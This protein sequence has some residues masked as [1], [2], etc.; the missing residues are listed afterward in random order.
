M[1]IAVY[2]RVSSKAQDTKSQ[3][4]DLERW[5]DAYANG[6]AVK[7]YRDKFTGKT[8]E[9]KG[10]KQL[11][12]DLEAG[13]VSKILVWRLDRIGRTA[14]GL[15]KLFDYLT[16]KKIT[17]ISIKDGLDLGTSAGRLMA[18]VLASV[19]QYET[20]V[21]AERVLAGQAVAK[22]NGKTWGGSERGRLVTVKP[23]Q[24]EAVKRYHAEGMKVAKI[25][26]TV[27]VSRPTVYRLLEQSA[28]C[29]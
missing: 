1:T 7:I 18:N 10:W 25:A 12:T 17:L 3:R 16:A 15:T 5:V 28:T 22:A 9:R 4:P 14:S 20:E 11:E 13:K 19:A 8:M 24:V 26:R 27:G 21:R 6:E 23:E 2:E 29:P